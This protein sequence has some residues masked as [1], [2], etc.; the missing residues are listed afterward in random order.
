MNVQVE[1][2]PLG[3]SPGIQIMLCV[4]QYRGRED[5]SVVV[6]REGGP[7]RG[8]VAIEREERDHSVVVEGGAGDGGERGKMYREKE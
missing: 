1:L 6:G 8:S 7:G 4:W 5:R 3:T 2:P